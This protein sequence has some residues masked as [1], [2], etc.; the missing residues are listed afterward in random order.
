MT[1][2]KESSLLDC[3]AEGPILHMDFYIG[4]YNETLILMQAS[5]HYHINIY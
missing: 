4:Q 5:R 2:W 3:S 1:F